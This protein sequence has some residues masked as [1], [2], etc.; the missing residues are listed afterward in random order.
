MEREAPTANARSAPCPRSP[1]V[2]NFGHLPLVR[3]I[4]YDFLTVEI[5]DRI[6]T[7]TINRPDKLNALNARVLE[8]LDGVFS[9]FATDRQV[10]AAIITGA[11]RAF[12]A[13]ADIAEIATLDSAGLEQ[14]SAAGQ[15][16]F[17]RIERLPK[18][19]IAA[20]NGFALGGG[21]E[22]ALACHIRVASEH[23]KFGLPEVKLG[24][25]PGYGGTQRLPRLVGKARALQL[26]LSG[27]QIDAT[28]AYRIGLVDA[29]ATAT[30]LREVAH[31]IALQVSKNGPVAVARALEA[32]H[33]GFD[34]LTDDAMAIEARLFGSLGATKDMAEGT[35]AF[36]AKR[37]AKF[38]GE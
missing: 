23:A 37:P 34:R 15:A 1:R 25:I 18:P 33:E 26:I 2:R 36:L 7:V 22:L 10:G 8:E 6:A 24:L 12:V 14:M 3:A 16:I 35:A 4:P 30:T 13:G 29:V 17:S 19:V 38:T 9:A 31:S 32:V 21:C 20:V 27:E 11:G 5:A 28:E